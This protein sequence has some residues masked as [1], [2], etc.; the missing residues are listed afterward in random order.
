MIQHCPI[1][2]SD[3]SPGVDN[4]IE[5]N[6]VTSAGE[7]L[8]VNSHKYP[9]LFWAL[10]GG[11]GGTYG[12]VTSVTYRT[13]P[14]L[15]LTAIFFVANSTTSDVTTF[16]KVFAEF[17]R[18]QPNLS[19]AGFSGYAEVLPGAMAWFYMGL[20]V[21]QAQANQTVDPFFAFARNFTD[22]DIPLAFTTPYPSFYEWYKRLYSTGQTQVGGIA[23][24][25]SRL[26]TRDTLE[27]NP[28]GIADAIL[29]LDGAIWQYAGSL[30]GPA[31]TLLIQL[32]QSCSWRCRFK[33]GP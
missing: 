31:R 15:P 21:T 2:N 19:D 25:A 9:D 33:S 11:G 23:E 1:L 10:R 22:L 3:T 6:V 17:M 27:H 26:I 13:H 12:V 20:N 24:L 30:Y 7:F 32:L 18:I 5:L 14:S 16:G 8:T 28:Q 29:S 4:V